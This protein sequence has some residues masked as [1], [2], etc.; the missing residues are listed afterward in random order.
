MPIVVALVQ[1][2]AASH[3]LSANGG[4]GPNPTGTFW[5]SC[6]PTGSPCSA[7]NTTETWGPGP[8]WYLA[9]AAGASFFAAGATARRGAPR[10]LN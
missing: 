6:S 9:L 8:G 3:D 5:G 7:S 10:T 2:V 1:P 4:G